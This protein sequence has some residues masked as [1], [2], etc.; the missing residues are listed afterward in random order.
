VPHVLHTTPSG[1]EVATGALSKMKSSKR[2][3][4]L[5]RKRKINVFLIKT[6]SFP[7]ACAPC[8]AH[9]TLRG[10]AVAAGVSSKGEI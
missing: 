6:Y 7:F 9:H 2:S 10:V 1:V 5:S 3:N 4:S 8:A